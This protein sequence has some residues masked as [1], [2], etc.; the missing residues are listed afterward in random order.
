MID[1]RLKKIRKEYN[2][3]YDLF[4]E[5]KL[6]KRD[7]LRREKQLTFKGNQIRREFSDE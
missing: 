2:K 7:W 5:G 6:R 1:P 3:I 4:M